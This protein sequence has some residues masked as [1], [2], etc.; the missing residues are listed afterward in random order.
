MEEIKKRI[1][2]I[3]TV[4]QNI[5]V[6]MSSL[7]KSVHE[8]AINVERQTAIL[9]GQKAFL[10]FRIDAMSNEIAEIKTRVG[11]NHSN[12]DEIKGKI[13][14]MEGAAKGAR[15]V[16]VAVWGAIGFIVAYVVPFFSSLFKG[17]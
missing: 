4:E 2:I 7:S 12:I 13:R 10:D 8:L 16:G 6:E 15:W 17:G 1:A 11:E 3:E 14:E 9:A 5:Q